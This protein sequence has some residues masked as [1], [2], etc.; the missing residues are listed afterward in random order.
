VKNGASTFLKFMVA[1]EISQGFLAP[2]GRRR[3]GRMAGGKKVAPGKPGA[4][5]GLKYTWRVIRY[6]GT[7]QAAA[8]KSR[9]AL[10]PGNPA[11]SSARLAR[12]VAFRPHLTMGLAFAWEPIYLKV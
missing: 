8:Q 3:E 12:P 4:G 1:L 6:G 2:T 7:L 9:I 5:E 10:I 11:V